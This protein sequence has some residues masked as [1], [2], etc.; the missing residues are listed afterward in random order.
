ML[1]EHSIDTFIYFRTCLIMLMAHTLLQISSK[2]RHTY[3]YIY[4]EEFSMCQIVNMSEGPWPSDIIWCLIIW[5]LNQM[6]MP[7]WS[8]IVRRHLM[9]WQFFWH[10]ENTYHHWKIA[11]FE[12]CMYIRI[13][14]SFIALKIDKNESYSLLYP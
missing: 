11:Y 10:I 8:W 9:I 7:N 1:G 14:L 5:F 4:W 2:L 13:T 6:C 12:V 3:V